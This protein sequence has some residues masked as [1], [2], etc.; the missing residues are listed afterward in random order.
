MFAAAAGIPFAAWPAQW[1]DPGGDR[2]LLV[3]TG[4]RS[5][6]HRGSLDAWRAALQDFETGFAQPLWQA[7]RSG[8][9]SRLQI[10]ILGEG[11]MRRLVLARADAWAF[12]RRAKPLSG[13]S[14]V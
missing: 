7:L 14:M 2:Q 12:W 10:D 1:R 4:L 5:A 6:L 3:W 13:Y 11:G 9:I 8:H